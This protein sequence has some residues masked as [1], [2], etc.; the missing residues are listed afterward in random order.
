MDAWPACCVGGIIPSDPLTFEGA[1][2]GRRNQYLIFL[3]ES[4]PQNKKN[5][6]HLIERGVM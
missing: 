4:L 2:R 5:P 3:P 1:A 6:P